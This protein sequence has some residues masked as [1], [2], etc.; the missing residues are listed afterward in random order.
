MESHGQAL[1]HEL[2][3]QK[4]VKENSLSEDDPLALFFDVNAFKS[5]IVR[6]QTAFGH[7]PTEGTRLASDP[8]FCFMF[9]IEGPCSSTVPDL[10]VMKRIRITKDLGPHQ[11][12]E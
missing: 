5:A 10:F 9:D 8:S 6:L 2:V 4:A 7:E 11:V 1:H 3:V 12:H